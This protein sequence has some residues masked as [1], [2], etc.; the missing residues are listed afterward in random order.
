MKSGCLSARRR[1]TFSGRR[2]ASRLVWAW[3]VNAEFNGPLTLFFVFCSFLLFQAKRDEDGGAEEA[4]V[5]PEVSRMLCIVA[6]AWR[7]PKLFTS[8]TQHNFS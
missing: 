6:L 8:F 4:T 7:A 1:K 2:P 3:T 5:F